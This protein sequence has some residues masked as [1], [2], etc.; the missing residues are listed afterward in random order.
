[1]LRPLRGSGYV[2]HSWV[3]SSTSNPASS[4]SPGDLL[5]HLLG[6]RHVGARVVSPWGSTTRPRV[7]RVVPARGEEAEQRQQGEHAAHREPP[8]GP[9]LPP[10]NPVTRRGEQRVEPHVLRGGGRAHAATKSIAESTPIA[11]SRRARSARG[12]PGRRRGGGPGN[13]RQEQPRSVP[14]EREAPGRR[15]PGPRPARGRSP[16]GPPTSRRR[17]PPRSTPPS[18]PRAPGAARHAV[19]AWARR[20]LGGQLRQERAPVDPDVG[21]E[22]REPVLGRPRSRPRPCEIVARSRAR[23][24]GRRWR[25]RRGPRRCA[26]PA[27]PAPPRAARALGRRTPRTPRPRRAGLRASWGCPRAPRARAPR[28]P[29][30]AP[31][32]GSARPRPPRSARARRARGG[33]RRPA[34]PR[35]GARTASGSPSENEGS[36]KPAPTAEGAR[37]LRGGTLLVREASGV[38]SPQASAHRSPAARRRRTRPSQCYRAHL[39]P[40]VGLRGGA[41]RSLSRPHGRQP[42]RVALHLSR[43]AV[44]RLPERLHRL[45]D[46]LHGERARLEDAPRAR[47]TP[48]ATGRP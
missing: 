40:P 10:E 24:H 2:L 22:V 7:G 18:A 11:W 37:E 48:R 46:A 17:A 8:G 20:V 38:A 29:W 12:S 16:R 31:P 32:A 1:M 27:P 42:E 44:G 6:Q 34:R 5:R 13:G 45:L 47:G 41:P 36:W 15:P 21:L 39:H 30:R 19:R 25:A 33:A 28:A 9:M 4:R 23:A 35:T 3:R 43:R 14:A 26:S